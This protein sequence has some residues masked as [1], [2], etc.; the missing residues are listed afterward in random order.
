M[1]CSIL[2]RKLILLIID[3]M[4]QAI[5]EHHQLTEGYIGFTPTEGV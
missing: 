3:I 1:E 5:I 2:S 4:V